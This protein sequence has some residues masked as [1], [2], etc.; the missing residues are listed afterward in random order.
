MRWAE[1][2][3]HAEKLLMA[4]VLRRAAYDHVLYKRTRKLRDKL[5]WKDAYIWLFDPSPEEDDYLMSCNNICRML[6]RDIEEIR[7][8]ARKMKRQDIKKCDMVDTHGRV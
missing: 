5:T 8:S 7:V 6:D 2:E 3:A 4:N 1:P